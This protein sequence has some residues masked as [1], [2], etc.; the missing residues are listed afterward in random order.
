MQSSSIFKIS[1][2]HV[3]RSACAPHQRIEFVRGGCYVFIQEGSISFE[4]HENEI[5][6]MTASEPAPDLEP[7][8]PN[9]P[10]VKTVYFITNTFFSIVAGEKG[11]VFS[12][13]YPGVIKRGGEE[14][15][16]CL[17]Y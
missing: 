17:K 6:N 9:V 7:E 4:P 12:L 11:C 1:R 10:R 5:L 15:N 3:Y 13:Y 2:R 16:P 14:E 8:F